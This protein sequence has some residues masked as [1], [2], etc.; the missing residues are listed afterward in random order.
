MTATARLDV[1]STAGWEKR[2][3]PADALAA[4]I[5]RKAKVADARALSSNLR[6]AEADGIEDLE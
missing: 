1:V 4:E 5:R 6:P 3:E 2:S